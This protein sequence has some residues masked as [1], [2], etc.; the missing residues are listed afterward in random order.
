MEKKTIMNGTYSYSDKETT[1]KY[2]F[3]TLTKLHKSPY[4]R[5]VTLWNTLPAEV[6]KCE[7][8]VEF[9]KCPQIPNEKLPFQKSYQKNLQQSC[10]PVVTSISH[11]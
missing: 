6:Q 9:K 11:S 2:N 3:S 7:G 4:Y 1:M 8:K 5:G 10:I